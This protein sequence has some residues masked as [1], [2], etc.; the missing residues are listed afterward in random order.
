MILQFSGHLLQE[1]E[2]ETVIATL[3]PDKMSNILNGANTRTKFFAHASFEND[4]QVFGKKM[5]TWADITHMKC[6]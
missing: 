1:G 3:D 4:A 5:G 2:R 6:A